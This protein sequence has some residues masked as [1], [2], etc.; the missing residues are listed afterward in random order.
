M[1]LSKLILWNVLLGLGFMAKVNAQDGMK[2]FAATAHPFFVKNC[3]ECHGARQAPLFALNNVEKTYPVA[4]RLANFLVPGDSRV[5]E[6]SMN[7]HCGMTTCMGDGKELTALITEWAKS[8]SDMP[9]TRI[10]TQ[11]V[12]IPALQAGQS[13]KLVFDLESVQPSQVGLQGSKLELDV[14]AYS[15]DSLLFRRPRIRSGVL[16]VYIRD[17]ELELNG[18][19][20]ASVRFKTI[21]QTV[22]QGADAPVLSSEKILIARPADGSKLRVSFG[23]LFGTQNLVAC[24]NQVQFQNKVLP[25]MQLRNCYYCHGGGERQL[26]G[27]SP[28]V[29]MWDMRKTT[30]LCRGALQRSNFS[31]P[32]RSPLIWFA[33]GNEETHPKS[34]PFLDEI[35]PDWTNWIESEK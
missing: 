34:I 20:L 21:D 10:R 22:A 25:I 4:R 9:S 5:V 28:A 26:P 23:T 35:A 24:K 6:R 31:Q 33:V 32:M 2:A 30:D 8:E 29:D 14:S 3:G 27:I 1:S 17:V 16:S 19:R 13:T 12:L 7:G 11:E 15:D 18:M